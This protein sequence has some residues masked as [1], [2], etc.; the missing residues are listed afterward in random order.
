MNNKITLLLCIHN[1]Q[2]VG[3]FDWVYEEAYKKAY[4]PFIDV[5]EEYYNIKL[6]LHYSGSL[7]DWLIKNHPDFIGRLK[8]F[9]NNGQVEILSGGYYEPIFPLIPEKDR[10]GQI[11]N[12]TQTLKQYTGFSPK[13]CW[14]PERVWEPSLVKSLQN[15]GINYTIVDDTHFKRYGP[16]GSVYEAKQEIL[17]YYIAEEEGN[18]LFIFPS[19]K[20]LRYYIPFKLPEETI[21]LL[22]SITEHLTATEHTPPCSITFADDGEK[23]GLWPHTYKW[24]YQEGWLKKFFK[25][26]EDNSEWITLSTFSE[27]I[28]NTKP[29]GLVYLPPCSYDEMLEWSGGYFRNF[30]TRYPEANNMHKK[31][32]YVSAKL[33]NQKTKNIAQRKRLK[34]ATFELYKGQANCA[35]WH[36]VFGGLYLRHLRN[37]IYDH[38]IEAEKIMNGLAGDGSRHLEAKIFDFDKDG[39]DEVILESKEL[40]V[41]I[42]PAYGGS[43][44]ELDY[45]PSSVNIC[46]V[47]ARRYEPYHKKIVN[48]KQKDAE[49]D[50]PMSIHNLVGVKEEGLENLLVYDPYK[51]NSLIEHMFSKDIDI[52]D[53]VRGN[54]KD[55]YNFIG[56]SFI[57]K[58]RTNGISLSN[59]G[60]TKSIKIKK[61]GLVSIDYELENE[62]NETLYARFGIEFNL[63]IRD[64]DFIKIGELKNIDTLHLKDSDSKLNLKY[65]FDKPISLWYYPIETV[66]ESEGGLE[67]TYQ[68]LCLLFNSII[69]VLP[70]DRWRLSLCLR[71]LNG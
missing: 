56:A 49:P 7:L 4:L 67:K 39:C 13:G 54:Y 26:L 70:K 36:G 69:D 30:I 22:K 16:Q 20:N 44:F 48:P 32:L 18:T 43:I 46:N 29:E 24:V 50:K 37:A 35:Y 10:I 68:G 12:F 34:E 27:H 65:Q 45:K 23:F 61:G 17:N 58:S 25:A 63:N 28:K 8:R 19:S 51:R 21:A 1:H 62:S 2:P 11:Q 3:N 41:Y 14:L 5:L 55:I 66:S 40:N 42:D 9:V 60:L 6:S 53:F 33:N 59:K 64:P 57:Y 38:L 47:I 31:M 15:A 52:A 71:F